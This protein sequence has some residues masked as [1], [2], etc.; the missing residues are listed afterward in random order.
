MNKPATIHDLAAVPR[1]TGSTFCYPQCADLPP[2]DVPAWSN[3]FIG[4]SGCP[5][6]VSSGHH[7]AAVMTPFGAAVVDV[8][9]VNGRA[10]FAPVPHYHMQYAR[11]L[12]SK[13]GCAILVMAEA[14]AATR[15][16]YQEAALVTAE[17][18]DIAP[19]EGRRAWHAMLAA[20]EARWAPYHAQIARQ[21]ARDAARGRPRAYPQ[22]PVAIV[23]GMRT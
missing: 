20:D 4:E 9:S 18:S 16:G 19:S 12:S 10:W 22:G 6:G 17:G 15:G 23:R 11:D 5:S 13:L 7:V 14:W 1:V 2:R 3:T 8:H 21:Q